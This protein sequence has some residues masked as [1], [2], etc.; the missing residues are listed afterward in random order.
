MGP[1]ILLRGHDGKN[2]APWIA[3][4]EVSREMTNYCV[5]PWRKLWQWE[6]PPLHKIS[7]LLWA[8]CHLSHIVVLAV[9]WLEV[10]IPLTYISSLSAIWE[11]MNL[12]LFFAFLRKLTLGKFWN[13]WELQQQCH[14]NKTFKID[15]FSLR[16][17]VQ[18]SHA[19]PTY[20]GL[21]SFSFSFVA[22]FIALIVLYTW[23][24]K[25]DQ[26]FKELL[27]SVYI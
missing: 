10:L 12:N 6:V 7:V 1:L 2:H 11:S 8:S 20:K 4:D 14:D 24:Q 22:Q 19:M 18:W 16:V 9:L 15:S 27:F 13:L 23:Q 26:A 17:S 25:R 5:L 21:V 3:S